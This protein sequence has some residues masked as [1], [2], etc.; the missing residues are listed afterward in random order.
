MPLLFELELF[1]AWWSWEACEAQRSFRIKKAKDQSK[2]LSLFYFIF[3]LKPR[4]KFWDQSKHGICLSS[5]S[6]V[7]FIIF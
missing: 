7:F 2:L 4:N 5:S 1:S 6:F 3:I